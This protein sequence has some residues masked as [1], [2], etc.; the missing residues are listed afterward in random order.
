[1]AIANTAFNPT[2]TSLSNDPFILSLVFHTEKT[3]T[4]DA[5]AEI[6]KNTLRK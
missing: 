2:E 6:L 5:T 3:V 1:M 4:L